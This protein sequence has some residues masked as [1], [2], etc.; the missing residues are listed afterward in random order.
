MI[1]VLSKDKIINL[2]V[3][4]KERAHHSRSRKG[5]HVFLSWYFG[6]YNLLSEEE[7]HDM[8]PSSN[9][10]MVGNSEDDK[11]LDSASTPPAIH[12]S[13]VMK[14][15]ASLWKSLAREHKDGWIERANQLNMTPLL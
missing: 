6:K 7:N 5:Y 9:P 8:F 3:S 11:S 2:P 13:T 15:A 4:S 10:T 12:V 14:A 1:L